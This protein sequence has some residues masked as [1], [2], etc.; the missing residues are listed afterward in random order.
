MDRL[1]SAV[2]RAVNPLSTRVTMWWQ[3]SATTRALHQQRYRGARPSRG[4][5]PPPP[6]L[7]R[8][9]G[10][11]PSAFRVTPGPR[12]SGT[13]VVPD[14]GGLRWDEARAVLGGA[15]LVAVH[16]DGPFVA[17]SGQVGG[18]VIGQ[19]PPSSSAVPVGAWVTLWVGDGPGS[20]GVREPRRPHPDPGSA[21]LARAEP[22]TDP[23][24]RP[25]G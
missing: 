22:A 2:R 18:V 17:A 19:D 14:V 7:L 8:R 6:L 5:D 10:I 1:E 12:T 24:S 16:P 20:A 23:D 4:W 25:D 11:R 21:S 15:G 9:G 13:V 3:T